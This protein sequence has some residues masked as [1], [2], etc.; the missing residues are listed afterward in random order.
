MSTAVGDRC[1]L[2]SPPPPHSPT[3]HSQ[4][5]ASHLKNSMC[6]FRT[7][8]TRHLISPLPSL[9]QHPLIPWAQRDCLCP[10]P[11]HSAPLTSRV[12][13]KD[14]GENFKIASGNISAVALPGSGRVVAG[15]SLLILLG[16]LAAPA[17]DQD[18]VPT[19]INRLEP[20][21]SPEWR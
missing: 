2:D 6:V 20:E 7:P 17:R 19:W 4:D 18:L 16:I 5:V 10:A 15:G 9:P 8:K 3:P 21:R 12:W 1:Q 14:K 11:T 13:R